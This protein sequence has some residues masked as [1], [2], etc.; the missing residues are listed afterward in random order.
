MPNRRFAQMICAL[1]LLGGCGGGSDDSAP[2]V[3]ISE[4]PD[5]LASHACYALDRCFQAS[6]LDLFAGSDCETEL[7]TELHEGDFALLQQAV[8]DG[9]VHYDGTKVDACMSAIEKAGCEFLVR[10]L[11][12]LCP[13]VIKGSVELGGDCTISAE[14]GKDAFCKTDAACPGTCTSLLAEGKSC[15]DDDECQDRL[16]CGSTSDACVAPGEEGDACGG[17]DDP[18]CAPWLLCRQGDSGGSCAQLTDVFA[19]ADGEAC[20]ATQQQFCNKGLTC[21]LTGIDT[22]QNP[23]EPQWQCEKPTQ[24]PDC[25]AA[26]PEQC[27]EGQYCEL[28]AGSIT[29]SCKPAPDE[30]QACASHVPSDASS[31]R[32]ICTPG[33]SCSSA[34]KCIARAHLHKACEIDDDCYSKH[35]ADGVCVSAVCAP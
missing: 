2:A 9:R 10:R 21:A 15:T 7:V 28:G 18:P 16:E 32:D 29:G 12:A 27:P 4:L 3:A 13:D 22:S 35:C 1:C 34:G 6:G 11:S 17:S 19:A 25:H 24:G 30:G 23:A 33:L 8:D 5:K 31:D 26:Y 14:C 20:D